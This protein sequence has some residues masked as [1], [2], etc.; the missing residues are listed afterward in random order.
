MGKLVKGLIAAA[1]PV[2]VIVGIAS[3]GHRPV[4]M[5]AADSSPAPIYNYKGYLSPYGSEWRINN[6]FAQVVDITNSGWVIGNV[7]V[8]QYGVYATANQLYWLDSCRY[9]LDTTTGEITVDPNSVTLFYV[10]WNTYTGTWPA[11]WGAGGKAKN[12][13]TTIKEEITWGY[14]TDTITQ[15]FQY[16]QNILTPRDT[17]RY[18]QWTYTPGEENLLYSTNSL[19]LSFDGNTAYWH[20]TKENAEAYALKILQNMQSQTTLGDEGSQYQQG[21]NQGYKQ[22]ETDGT[23][24]GYAQGYVQGQENAEGT[25]Y[26]QGFIDG[27][28]AA[29]SET[30]AIMNLFSAIVSVPIGVF[31]GLSPLTIWNTPIVGIILTFMS[32]SVALWLIRKVLGK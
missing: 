25:A 17:T 19:P 23:N 29:T 2:A 8:G 22:G 4:V 24:V 10:S 16:G 1:I 7:Q 20:I 32:L 13:L 5:A 12:L 3:C 14:A 26:N 15:V 30:Q 6:K 9:T 21:Y 11:Q 27:Q 31:N 28:N 18:G